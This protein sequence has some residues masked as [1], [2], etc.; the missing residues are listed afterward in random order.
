V[1]KGHFPVIIAR[2]YW[3]ELE[4]KRQVHSPITIILGHIGDKKEG[5]GGGGEIFAQAGLE[6]GPEMFDGIEI[7]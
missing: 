1:G 3:Q 2:L 4:Y 5:V 7:R 6:G